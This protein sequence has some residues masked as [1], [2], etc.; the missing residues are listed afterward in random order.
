MQSITDMK[1]PII[2]IIVIVA[3]G[4]V[5]WSIWF[6][7]Y[8]QGSQ[9]NES[10]N[11]GSSL[12]TILPSAQSQP[13]GGAAAPIQAISSPEN[14]DV[15]KDFLSSMQN[16]GQVALGG[17]VV[18]SP[19]ALQVWGDTNM[20]GEA[21]LEYTSST[22]WVL[23]SLGGGEWTVLSL[24]QEGVPLATAKQLIAGLTNST[25][26]SIISPTNVPAGSTV[27]IGT[28]QGSVMVNNFYKNA[29][30]IAQ[31]QN[32]VV[33]QQ[34]VNYGI[35]YNILNSG[36]TITIFSAPFDAVRQ[37]AEVAFLSSLNISQQDACKLSV[38][39]NASG[40]IANEYA[41]QSFPLSFCAS[42]TFGG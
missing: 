2:I 27:T 19:Y 6:S 36:F 7:V 30:Y 20:G 40:N 22:R 21:L 17:T 5:A 8:L 24:M 37:T 10:S 35:F 42:S 28:S 1:R 14:S 3:I 18:V 9:N 29:D 26:S 15:A 11:T 23:L 13:Q 34:T 4:L 41:G 32:A 25:P 12:P 39:E 38:Y 31:D 16:E 33:I